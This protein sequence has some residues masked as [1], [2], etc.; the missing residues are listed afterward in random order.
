MHP[1]HMLGVVGIFNDSQFN[2]MNGCLIT[3]SLIRK[4]TE[5]QSANASEN[6]VRR[7]ILTILWLLMI[8]AAN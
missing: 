2:A 7:K 1:F 8:I 6:L 5:N 3:S 4:T